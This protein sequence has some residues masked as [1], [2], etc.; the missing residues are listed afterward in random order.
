MSDPNPTDTVE[1][2]LGTPPP[3]EPDATAR[4]RSLAKNEAAARR[5]ENQRVQAESAARAAAAEQSVADQA[6]A[7]VDAEPE[8]PTQ[9]GDGAVTVR[10][11][12]TSDQFIFGQN[13]DHQDVVAQAGG[14]PVKIPQELWDRIKTFTHDVF[15]EIS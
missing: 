2:A 12:G 10:Y 4:Q 3:P 8:K 7:T 1:H 13:D 14:D 9:L 15:E 11:L 5:D 6:A